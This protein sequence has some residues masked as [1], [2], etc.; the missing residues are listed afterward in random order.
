M[1]YLEVLKLTLK[2]FLLNK[3]ALDKLYNYKNGGLYGILTIFLVSVADA[4]LSLIIPIFFGYFGSLLLVNLGILDTGLTLERV[5]LI[6]LL[7]FLVGIFA[8]FIWIYSLFLVSSYFS[9]KKVTFSKFFSVSANTK[10]MLLF[11]GI[12][13]TIPFVGSVLSFPFLLYILV[14]DVYIVSRYFKIT[15]EK[16][17][18]IVISLVLIFILIVILMLILIAII[19]AFLFYF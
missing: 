2:S 14:L 18:I 12:L 11:F 9:R 16:S 5:F 7:G 17:T 4:I 8:V 19:W 1:G 3:K 13:S 6:V 10:F 15:L